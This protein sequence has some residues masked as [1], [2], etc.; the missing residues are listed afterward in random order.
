MAVVGHFKLDIYTLSLTDV[1]L[2]DAVLMR[3]FHSLDESWLVLLEAIDCAGLES[4]YAE[5]K[6]GDD[7]DDNDSEKK[8]NNDKKE[9]KP[10]VTLSGLLNCVDGTT[11]PTGHVLITS[12]N[13]LEKLDAA[14]IRPGRVDRRIEFTLASREQIRDLF[15]KLYGAI[16]DSQEPTK[17]DA[18]LVPGFAENSANAVPAGILS[19]AQIQE[20]LLQHR[21]R[22][23]VVVAKARAVVAAHLAETIPGGN[24]KVKSPK[25]TQLPTPNP[26]PNGESSNHD[27]PLF[28]FKEIVKSP[29]LPSAAV[30]GKSIDLDALVT[31]IDAAYRDYENAETNT[32]T[33]TEGHSV[34]K[35]PMLVIT[36]TK[37]EHVQLPCMLIMLAMIS[38]PTP[39]KIWKVIQPTM[40][41]IVTILT[42]SNG[43]AYIV[44]AAT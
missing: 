36:A 17:Y 12:T 21:G 2:T 8:K 20:Y 22:P 29:E 25:L 38:M 40:T 9:K 43:G 41:T 42:V 32:Q 35:H 19:L 15:V 16:K 10:K 39:T 4:V 37:D 5:K 31:D 7:S 34:D 44:I 23:E 6:S 1:N 11:A 27:D 30:T 26:S 3:L 13:C 18:A 14:L 28:N 33:H 24:K